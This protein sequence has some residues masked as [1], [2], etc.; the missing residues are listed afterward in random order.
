MPG[1]T[2][3][4]VQ[5]GLSSSYGIVTYVH[6]AL[7]DEDVFHAKVDQT[8]DTLPRLSCRGGR[9]MLDADSGETSGYVSLHLGG[10]VEH[11]G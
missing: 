5:L 10:I 9:K 7:A 4:D 8:E 3:E 6:R 2:E 1:V 11:T